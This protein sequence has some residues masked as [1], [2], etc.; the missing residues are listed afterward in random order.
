MAVPALV[1]TE[2][3]V[4]PVGTRAAISEVT[5]P[6]GTISA[7]T[8]QITA[9]DLYGYT[10]NIDDIVLDGP[11]S[12]TMALTFTHDDSSLE[13][14]GLPETVNVGGTLTVKTNQTSGTYNGTV[15]VIVAYE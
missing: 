7:A 5:L 6:G 3:T 12:D 15:E 1:E 14:T 11:S 2:V 9:D 13:G 10:I 4:L 8:F